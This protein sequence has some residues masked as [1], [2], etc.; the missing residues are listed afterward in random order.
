LLEKYPKKYPSQ[1]ALAKKIGVSHD[2]ISLWLK[3]VEVVPQ[4]V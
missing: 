1:M 4:E 3:T 2:T